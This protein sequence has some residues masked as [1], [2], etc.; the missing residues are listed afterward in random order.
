[1]ICIK[2]HNFLQS[3]SKSAESENCSKQHADDVQVDM[4]NELDTNVETLVTEMM[5]K[6]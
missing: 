1:M 2:F 5:N 4:I 6:K 3:S